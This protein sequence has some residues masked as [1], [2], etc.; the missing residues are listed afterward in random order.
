MRLHSEHRR[1]YGIKAVGHVGEA[2]R[3]FFVAKRHKRKGERFVRT[4]GGEHVFFLHSQVVRNRLYELFRL[5][6]VI[7]PQ[8]L[9]YLPHRAE[10]R[11]AGAEKRLVRVE[12]YVLLILRLFPGSIGGESRQ[13]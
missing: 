7:Q 9:G 1:E 10:N 8:P 4:V 5:R 13:P 6:V 12:F 11:G 3:P 2:R